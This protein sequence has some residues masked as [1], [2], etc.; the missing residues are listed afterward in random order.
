MRAGTPNKAEPD[1]T[2]IYRRAKSRKGAK[3]SL[4]NI[5]IEKFGQQSQIV[6]DKETK[7]V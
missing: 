2:G 5:A 7:F 1:V 6:L 4:S 3:K